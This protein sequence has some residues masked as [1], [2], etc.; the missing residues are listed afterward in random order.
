MSYPL[1]RKLELPFW[2]GSRI[3]LKRDAMLIRIFTDT[4]L[5]G[6]A[7]GPAHLRAQTEIRDVIAPFLVGKDPLKW[8]QFGFTGS[9]EICKTYKAVE[10]ALMDL[11]SKF[12][13]CPISDLLGGRKRERIKLYGSA[14]MYM[15]PEN[16][17]IEAKG[18]QELGFSAYKFRPALN[19]E[20]NLEILEGI[21]KATGDDMALMI[22]GHTWWRMGDNSYTPDMVKELSKNMQVYD[23][24]W[25]EEPLLP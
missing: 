8:R 18:A 7:P 24:Y 13:G 20:G 2:G 25:L 21:R 9:S 17:A 6:F 5:K 22:D 1:P 12:E 3:I 14:G 15:S 19:P 16:Y 11:V 10:I 4:G 23:P